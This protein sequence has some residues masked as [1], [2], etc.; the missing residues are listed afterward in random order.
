MRGE[1]RMARNISIFGIYKMNE[2]AAKAVDLLREAGFRNTDISVL[3]SETPGNKDLG[4][5]KA[6]KA[7]E[8]AATG[9]GS[10]AILGGALGWLAGIG[11]LAIP[12]VGPFIAAGP[13]IGLLA[14][15]GA[16]GAVGGIAGALIGAGIPEY[17]AKRYEGRI[18]GGHA[19][20]SVHC[21]DG[22]WEHTAR[23]ILR[24]TGA[25]DIGASHEA[26]AEFDSSDR[27][28][29]REENPDRYEADFRRHF[30]TFYSDSG[31]T[32][33]ELAPFYEWGFR[34][35][36]SPQYRDKNFPDI[37]DDV[38]AQYLR[39]HPGSD[40]EKVSNAVLYGWE[41]AG[42]TVSGFVII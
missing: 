29:P 36:N 24:K 25:E 17:E 14:G 33:E 21:D 16:G 23:E 31:M 32:F 40:W 5:N 42:G 35:A 19:L 13:L 37:E 8:G 34:M 38:K 30:G 4:L 1:N 39:D 20:L 27:P 11:S 6:T 10:G 12:G 15:L 3:F 9:A 41:K 22:N 28:K 18:R 26:P 2:D 7:P